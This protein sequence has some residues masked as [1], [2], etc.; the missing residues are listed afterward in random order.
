M[1]LDLQPP[2]TTAAWLA[3]HGWEKARASDR[4]Q[5]PTPVAVKSD[6][7]GRALLTCRRPSS[8]WEVWELVRG[9]NLADVK[10]G[11]ELLRANAGVVGL[12][13]FVAAPR[14]TV[15]FRFDLPRELLTGR[16]RRVVFSLDTENFYLP[17]VERFG[18]PLS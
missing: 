9:A 8:G 15:V 4:W 3:E 17:R 14:N 5:H 18:V 12:G 1:K 10:P 16:V 2:Q 11:E 6:K 13:K 7:K